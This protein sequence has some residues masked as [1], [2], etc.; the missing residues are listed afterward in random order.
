MQGQVL[1]PVLK[2]VLLII[3]DGF[4]LRQE[5]DFNAVAIASTPNWDNYTQHYAFGAI[6]ASSEAVGLPKNQF[7]NSEVGHLNIG[8]GRIVEQDITRIDIAIANDEFFKNRVLLDALN[9]TVSGNVH[10]LGLLS[11]GGVH[12]HIAHIFALIELANQQPNIQNIWLHLFLDGRDTPPQSAGKY[13]AALNLQLHKFTKAK[14]ATLSGRYYAMDRDKRYDRLKLAYAAIVMADSMLGWHGENVLEILKA[15]YARGENDE[16]IQPHV[17]GNYPGFNAGDSVIFANFRSDRAIQLTDAILNVNEHL[18][19]HA[20]QL[21]AFVTMTC[22]DPKLG[23]KVAFPSAPLHNTL[24]EYV[25]SLGYTQLRIAETEKYPHVTY[26]FNGGKKEPNLN[27]DQILVASP[28]DVATYDLKPE[29]SLPE[30]TAK[31]VD[32]IYQNK[33]D[34]IIT[35]FANADM[36]GHSGNL[37]ATVKAVEAIDLALGQ[38]V[39]AMLNMDGEV[40]VIAD[41][42]NCEEMYD[43]VAHQPHTQHTTNLVPCLYIGRPAKIRAHGALKDVAPTLLA[44]SGLA[45]PKEMTGIN[46]IEFNSRS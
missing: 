33:Y 15:A 24:G 31:L 30:V 46:L 12:S 29:M 2:K 44:M 18:P 26:F 11:D 36:V 34:F 19:W 22:Y 32:A 27:E 6:D 5:Q 23:T 3:L 7:G 43:Y 4:G 21:S 45:K 40:L 20:V 38:V 13:L 37:A 39:M 35:N 8:A 1:E 16:F 9:N 10:I 42:G 17:I 14:I 41:H 25:A 28:R